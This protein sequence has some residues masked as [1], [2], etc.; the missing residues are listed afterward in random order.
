VKIRFLEKSRRKFLA[1]KD[2]AIG[3]KIWRNVRLRPPAL[4]RIYLN[5]Q[6][7]RNPLGDIVLESED[8]IQLPIVAFGPDDVSRF[9]LDQLRADAQILAISLKVAI[10]EISHP[11]PGADFGRIHLATPKWLN[12]VSGDHDHV[13]EPAQSGDDIGR[14]ALAQMPVGLFLR[15]IFQRKNCD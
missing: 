10:E 9:R 15:Q 12:G 2:Q 11:E 7:G 3:L 4:S 8:V 14:Y 13:P 1:T 6:Q 5:G